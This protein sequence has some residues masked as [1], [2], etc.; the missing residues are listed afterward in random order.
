MGVDSGA[1]DMF[2]GLSLLPTPTAAA[3]DAGAKPL[4]G[5][6]FVTDSPPVAVAPGSAAAPLGG[7]GLASAAS[8]LPPAG[9]QLFKPALKPSNVKKKRSAKRPGFARDD[10][11]GGGGDDDDGESVSHGGADTSSVHGSEVGAPRGVAPQPAAP[12]QSSSLLAGLNVRREPEGVLSHASSPQSVTDMSLAPS[13]PQPVALPTP[14]AAPTSGV[15]AGLVIRGGD[16]PHA[17]A[18]PPAPP[19][20][21][22]SLLQGLTLRTSRTTSLDDTDAPPSTS[23]PAVAPAAAAYEVA[24]PY[25]APDGTATLVFQNPGA[26]P[27]SDS[28]TPS[29][30]SGELAGDNESVAA[31]SVVDSASVRA[32]DATRAPVAATEQPAS[33]LI[34]SPVNTPSDTYTG[35]AP[36]RFHGS[37]ATTVPV[38]LTDAGKLESILSNLDI[39]ARAFKCVAVAL[40]LWARCCCCCCLWR[41]WRLWWRRRW[42]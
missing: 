22:S 17:A 28:E 11:G 20:A 9:V 8:A 35:A 32:V 10:D 18:A 3:V 39:S 33:H 40:L 19:A 37:T 31:A 38:A 12:A 42:R 26:R 29:I 7:L 41:W 21:P 36:P 1:G 16:A 25:S 4:S 24:N 5:F 34:P 2:G 23:A 14:S 27:R 15:L 13:V 6:G 30:V